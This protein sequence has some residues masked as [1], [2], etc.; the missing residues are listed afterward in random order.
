M[1]IKTM[2]TRRA[3]LALALLGAAAPAAAQRQDPP[4]PLP[5]RP[6]QFPAFRETT[7]PNGL[8]LIVVENHAHPVASVNLL[9]GSGSS[10][11]PA[12]RVGL[13]GVF[14]ELLPKGT[15]TRTGAEISGAIERTGGSIGAGSAEDYTTVYASVLAE[16]LPLA[17]ELVADVALNPSFPQDEVTAARDRALS[18]LQQWMADPGY[19]ANRRFGERLYGQ[20]PY[21][22]YRT[23][24]T[25]GALDRD[26]MVAFHRAHFT[27]GNAMLVV[28]GDVDGAQV[29]EMAQ[30]RFGG[31]R[32]GEAPRP[33]YTGIPAP[34][35]TRILLVHRPGAVQSSVRAGRNTIRAAD[36]DYPALLVLNKIL[37]GGTDSRLFNIL[38][39]QKGWTYGAF[40]DVDRP[41]DI[42]R[43][44]AGMEVRSEVTDSAVAE[45][46]TQ[47]RR[48]VTEPVSA[49]ELEAAKGYL[50][51]SFPIGIQTAEEVA[52]QVALTRLKGLPIEDLLQRRERISA[53][54]VD[55]VRRVAGR[56]L[57]PESLVVTV[58]GDAGRVL[59]GLER[60]AP[61]DLMDADG[62]PMDRAA[63]QVR[64]SGESFDASRL[65][66]YTAE[67][68]IAAQGNPIGRLTNTLAREGDGW[69]HAMDGSFGPVQQTITSVWGP[70]W[71]PRTYVETYAGAFEGRAEV[72]V[73]NGRFTGTAQMPP[74]A[75]GSKTFDA[76]AIA[77]AA[78][79]QME[80]AMLST[81]DLAEGKTIV[82]P[83][84]NTST[85]A[86]GPVTYTVGAV[87]S[88]TVPAGTFQAY[89]VSSTG[90]SSAMTLWLRAEGPH[91]VVKQELVGQPIVVQLKSIQ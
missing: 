6:L 19:L 72:R 78:W 49:Q 86:A 43:F 1:T 30:S 11:V 80:D 23:A 62:R 2:T 64:A 48:I 53:V 3:A 65:R 79:S 35:P 27:P 55:D 50:I 54:S 57:H 25:L 31:W 59:E 77:G 67:Y 17:M 84:F 8:R 91:I 21:G 42:G 66:P 32:G 24:E 63:L 85:G 13:A 83:V 88:V 34:A 40:S 90:G 33:A 22:R 87:E 74:Q 56:Y 68:E 26:A 45:M 29:M 9:V 5:S 70:A 18:Q 61:V 60:I 20:H 52:S 12:E 4:A 46:L 44:M 14:S 41:R 36:A 69:K 10:A 89:R 38:R 15:A 51:G 73:E 81:A 58:V 39:E 82:I 47:I 28:A 37:G 71:E 7:L 75:G 16:H 76:E